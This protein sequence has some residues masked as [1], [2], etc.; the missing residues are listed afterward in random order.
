MKN[1]AKAVV[2]VMKEVKSIKKNSTVGEG[3]NA[4]KGVQDM[5]VKKAIGDAMEKNGLCILPVG[6]EQVMDVNRWTEDSQY[7]VKQ[8]QS[9]FT[10]VKTKYLLLHES[11]ESIEIVGYGH[12]IDSQDKSAGKA[13]TYALKYALLYAFMVP[14]GDIDD[15][16]SAHSDDAQLPP[17]PKTN[18]RERIAKAKIEPDTAVAPK[19]VPE[20]AVPEQK[21]SSHTSQR[22]PQKLS[23]NLGDENWDKVLKFVVTNKDK[24]LTDIVKRLNAKYSIDSLESDPVQNAFKDA[25]KS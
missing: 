22:E 11:G 1:L 4:Y 18:L 24:G 3:R 2:A 15:T 19:E 10:E 6:V 23:L 7:G 25:I 20:K 9:V 14:T 8:K 17:P 16:D 12:G 21:D 13:T 5:D